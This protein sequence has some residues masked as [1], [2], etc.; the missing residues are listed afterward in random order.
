MRVDDIHTLVGTYRDGFTAYLTAYQVPGN[1]QDNNIPQR[2]PSRGSPN[3]GA[4]R[5]TTMWGWLW[6]YLWNKNI[7][8]RYMH[9]QETHHSAFSPL[10]L[11]SL[12][13]K[14][15]IEIRLRVS[16]S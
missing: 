2:I 5:P 4:A 12:L 3:P 1:T 13:E 14:T 11:F 8:S 7:S 16:V 10:S 15:S 9:F 6:K